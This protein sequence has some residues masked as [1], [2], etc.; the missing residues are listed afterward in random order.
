MNTI[1]GALVFAG[2]PLAVMGIAWLLIGERAGVVRVAAALVGLV[3]VALL[4]VRNPGAMDAL[5][6]I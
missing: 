1:E 6:L 4:V 2:I 3:G 5:G